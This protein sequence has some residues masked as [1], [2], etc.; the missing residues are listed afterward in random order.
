MIAAVVAN[1]RDYELDIILI[2]A[3]DGQIIRNLTKGFDYTN[4]IEYIATAGGLRGNLMPWIAWAPVGDTIAYFARTGKFKSLLLQ[5][6]ATGHI[7]KRLELRT[8]DGPES[9]SFSPDGKKVV[10]AALQDGITDIYIDRHRDLRRHQPDEGLRS[11]TSR[12]PSHPTAAP[13]CIPPV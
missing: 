1:S 9:P 3:K 10:F 7:E 11:P 8:V 6:V 5:N 12:R 4:R 2:S 13:S